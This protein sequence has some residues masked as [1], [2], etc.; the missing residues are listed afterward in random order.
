MS[1]L[2]FEL[3]VAND[4][5]VDEKQ[6]KRMEKKCKQ[7]GERFIYS[8]LEDALVIKAEYGEGSLCA[9]QEQID[10][11]EEMIDDALTKENSYA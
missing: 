9:T 11:V 5:D 10:N 6:M 8:R 2:Y 1:K 7:L 3:I 4:L